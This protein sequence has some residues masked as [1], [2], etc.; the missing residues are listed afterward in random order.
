MCYTP[1][2]SEVYE[3]ESEYSVGFR[4]YNCFRYVYCNMGF[5]KII[6]FIIESKL[7]LVLYMTFVKA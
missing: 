5:G 2:S 1:G 4:R 7:I 6:V 3:E